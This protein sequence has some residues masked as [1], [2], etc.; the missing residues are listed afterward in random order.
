MNDRLLESYYYLEDTVLK[1]K[2]IIEEIEKENKGL[3]T[4][5][6]QYETD[7]TVLIEEHGAD[8]D[9]KVD[10][11]ILKRMINCLIGKNRK[12]NK[13]IDDIEDW[14]MVS[15][16]EPLLKLIKALKKGERRN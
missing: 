10:R 4:M 7:A 14:G 15:F 2:K 13:I 8:P 12:L 6:D 16:D 1:Q 3:K 11:E 5:L 9:D